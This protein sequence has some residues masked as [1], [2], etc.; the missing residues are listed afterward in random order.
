M[1]L[2]MATEVKNMSESYLSAS[3]DLF[4]PMT[5]F[6][7]GLVLFSFII[8]CFKIFNASDCSFTSND[9]LE[10]DNFEMALREETQLESV[11][12]LE[13]DID[14][15]S[16]LMVKPERKTSNVKMIVCS[17]CLAPKPLDGTCPYCGLG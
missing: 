15:I 7:F 16:D 14:D 17:H 12:T 2:Q 1:N 4:R 3:L 10:G 8:R 11:V 9:I 13:S 5:F 6:G